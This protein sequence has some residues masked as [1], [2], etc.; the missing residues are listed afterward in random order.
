MLTVVEPATSFELTTF[1]RARMYLDFDVTDDVGMRESIRAA[2]RSIVNYCNRPFGVEMVRQHSSCRDD[3]GIVLARSPVRSIASVSVNGEDIDPE[4]YAIDAATGRLIRLDDN[5]ERIFWE[6]RASILYTAGYVLPSDPLLN[7]ADSTDLPQDVE[8]AAI[9]LARQ[10]RDRLGV[11][12]PYVKS[13]ETP[14]VSTK[15][16]WVPGPDETGFDAE[17]VQ[18]LAP[19]RRF[20]P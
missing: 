3:A 9:S 11:A 2:S 12:D 10:L 16:F 17:F 13:V 8:R 4:S 14:G 6:G 5:G 1:A 20:W 18:L 15:T 7:G 19:Y